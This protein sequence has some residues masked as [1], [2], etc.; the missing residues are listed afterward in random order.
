MEKLDIS[1]LI[2]VDHYWKIVGNHIVRGKGPTAMQSKLQY[3]LL[4]PLLLQSEP[5]SVWL[6]LYMTQ[7][8]DLELS[9]C[10]ESLT[11]S[12]LSTPTLSQ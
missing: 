12:C 3:L 7:T 11:N 2:G 5:E 1:L 4:G 10:T 6:H 8:L 9:D